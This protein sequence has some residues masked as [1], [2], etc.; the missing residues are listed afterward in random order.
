MPISAQYFLKRNFEQ[1]VNSAK[2]AKALQTTEWLWDPASQGHTPTSDRKMSGSVT[3]F[4][5]PS[6]LLMTTKLNLKTLTLV[7]GAGALIPGNKC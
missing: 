7:T 4:P 2:T 1:F 3:F 6:C 5:P